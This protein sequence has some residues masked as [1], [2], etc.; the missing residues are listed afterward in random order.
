MTAT[1]AT[2]SGVLSQ[3]QV[4]HILSDPHDDRRENELECHVNCPKSHSWKGRISRTDRATGILEC[5]LPRRPRVGRQALRRCAGR[6]EGLLPSSR[7]PSTE[8]AA[9]TK[10]GSA[11][12]ELGDESDGQVSQEGINRQEAYGHS[13]RLLGPTKGTAIFGRIRVN[14]DSVVRE[15]KDFPTGLTPA[16]C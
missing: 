5:L 10:D 6:P 2:I 9:P 8:R 13:S 16:F 3:Y 11:F 4:L 15:L 7:D 1:P 12:L 14:E